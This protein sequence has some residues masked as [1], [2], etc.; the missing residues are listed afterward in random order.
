MGFATMSALGRRVLIKQSLLE[1][2]RV[3]IEPRTVVVEIPW[4]I[5]SISTELIIQAL[6]NISPWNPVLV[7]DSGRIV[8][9]NRRFVYVTL[10]DPDVA[11]AIGEQYI[12]EVPTQDNHV[13]CKMKVMSDNSITVK[14]DQI[15]PHATSMDVINF[16]DGLGLGKVKLVDKAKS[17]GNSFFSDTWIAVLEPHPTVDL[18]HEQTNPLR[19][20]NLGQDVFTVR[21]MCEDIQKYCN[22]CKGIN[23]LPAKCPKKG[24]CNSC[25]RAGHKSRD[26]PDA[27]DEPEEPR[28]D[29]SVSDSAPDISLLMPE[30]D[31]DD[32]NIINV[33]DDQTHKLTEESSDNSSSFDNSNSSA[34][35]CVYQPEYD[36]DDALGPI[37]KS[38]PLDTGY[39]QSNDE[40]TET[41]LDAA[42]PCWELVETMFDEIRPTKMKLE[43][44]CKCFT[45]SNMWLGL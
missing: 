34:S 19:K 13:E 38:G 21:Y 36:S 2:E 14:L 42:E 22:A 37:A 6:K 4:H 25:S 41:S 23:H 24:I 40:S 39:Y 30:Q 5:G 1:H 43:T 44:V 15:P 16:L 18:W 20:F 12:L 9:D 31:S 3:D 28:F 35:S 7:L 33:D 26:C 29:K 32:K 27:K 10:S 17:R 45:L 11:I 8:K